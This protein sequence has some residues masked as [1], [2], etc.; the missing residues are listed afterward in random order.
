[1]QHNWEGLLT[2]RKYAKVAGCSSDTTLRDISG[3]VELGLLVK[4]QGGRA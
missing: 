1:M 2:T 3:L 4:N